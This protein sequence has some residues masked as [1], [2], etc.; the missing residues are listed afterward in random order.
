MNNANYSTCNKKKEG[1]QK[2]KANAN[3]PL[4][5]LLH[6]L[7][8]K[9]LYLCTDTYYYSLWKLDIVEL[10]QRIGRRFY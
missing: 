8:N 2:K 3:H 5:M 4:C 6:S 7:F 9:A 10:V 1:V